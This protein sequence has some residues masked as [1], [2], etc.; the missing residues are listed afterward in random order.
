MSIQQKKL[1][2][3]CCKAYL[4]EDDDVVY[5]P[6]CGAPHHRDCYNSIGHCALEELH[7]TPDEYDSSKVEESDDTAQNSDESS[8][9][10]NYTTCSMCGE[11]Y[12]KSLPKCPKCS[13]PD[14]SR[15]NGGFM[16]F[17]FLG[18]I[19]A[20]TDLGDGVTA[21]EAK[22][23]V[24]SNTH[25]YIP[26]FARLN[27]SKRISWNWLAFL[28]PGPWMFSRKMFTNGII[29]S[30]LTIISTLLTVPLTAALYG[31]GIPEMRNYMEL[32]RWMTE[33]LPEINKTVI[34][35]ALLGS[36]LGIGIKIVSA[37][38][39]DYMYKKHTINTVKSIKSSS[40]DIDNDFRKKGGINFIWFFISAMLIQ[41][42]PSIVVM[43]L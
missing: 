4:F 14:F 30:V 25:R 38:Y 7:G 20:N 28:L 18:G 29:T 31:L 35:V 21:D 34:V 15:M 32:F 9:D 23:F 36:V 43:F 17:D 12:D 39:A 22:R 33:K 1:S 40:D 37:M 13:A 10:Y 11:K 5:C 2:C 24:M 41:Y 27:K 6:V 3:A 8:T 19:P 26:K 16:Q 42:I